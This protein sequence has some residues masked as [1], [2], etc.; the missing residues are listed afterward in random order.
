LV[1]ALALVILR[2]SVPWQLDHR[3]G[4]RPTWLE[5]API[6]CGP[7]KSLGFLHDLIDISGRELFTTSRNPAGDI[8]YFS[9]SQEQQMAGKGSAAKP[10]SKTEV[11]S[12]LADKTGL[13]KKD[14]SKL[15][16]ALS[17]LI[18]DN[19][20]KK[21]P[22]VFQIP[23]LLK[24]TVVNKP[25]TKARKGINRFTGEEVMFKA[26]PARNVV[27]VRALSALKKMA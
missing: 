13:A 24:I 18:S 16:D 25:A 12:T 2:A 19:L 15:F 1:L 6:L 26:K 4:A 7:L 10:M 27:K 9:L 14:V 5:G 8:D 20:G 11:F 22:K 17:D 21:G 3:A 23:K